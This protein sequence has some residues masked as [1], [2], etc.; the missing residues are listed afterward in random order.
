MTVKRFKKI[1]DDSRQKRSVSFVRFGPNEP[2]K[3]IWPRTKIDISNLVSL[4]REN[5]YLHI[6]PI[7]FFIPKYFVWLLAEYPYPLG[8]EYLGDCKGRRRPQRCAV[9]MRGR[10]GKGSVRGLE[11]SRA[12]AT[13][14]PG[15]LE[16]NVDFGAV[17]GS[18]RSRD[19]LRL[20]Q[21]CRAKLRRRRP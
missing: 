20:G 5:P 2:Y 7:V 12:V 14:A 21:L 16:E 15:I 17:E 3:K 13:L 6:F 4:D 1:Q 18:V 19:P 8:L 10:R 9:Q 11:L